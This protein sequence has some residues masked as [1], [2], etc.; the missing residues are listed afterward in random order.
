MT[1]IVQ[2]AIRHGVSHVALAE[3]R[4]LMGVDKSTDVASD[5]GKSEAAVQTAVRLEASRVGARLWRQNVGACKDDTGRM[6]R[7]GLCNDSAALNKRIKSSD[8]VGI[9]P[10]IIT[11]DMVGHTIGQFIAREIKKPSWH[12]T[13][14][15][16]EKAQLAF[17]E[18]VIS[19]GGDFAFANSEGTL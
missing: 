8:L 6:I 12:Y 1:N 19:L 17:G 4:Q 13:G 7:Y 11:P 15:D 9:R 10:V 18:L 2:W 14:T 16:R 5:T 3:L